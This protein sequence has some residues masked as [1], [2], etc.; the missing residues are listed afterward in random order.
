MEG[1]RGGADLPPN[2]GMS[3]DRRVWSPQEDN[4]I[5]ELVTRYGTR[6]WSSIA[7]H[8]VSD[9]DI[10]GRTGKQCRE[11]WHNH[12]D[13]HINKEAW[14]VEEERIMADAHRTLGETALRLRA[15]V[16]IS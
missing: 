5:R 6:S 16:L 12:L 15:L 4:A 14:T 11:R 3:G 9:F 8:I 10:K 2:F 13:P 1:L 7:E